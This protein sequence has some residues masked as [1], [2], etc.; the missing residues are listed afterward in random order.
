M[1]IYYVHA[2]KERSINE[3]AKKNSNRHHPSGKNERRSFSGLLL[4]SGYGA[5]SINPAEI[6]VVQRYILHEEEHHTK[7]RFQNRVQSFSKK[8]TKWNM[9]KSTFGINF[10]PSESK[11]SD[12]LYQKHVILHRHFR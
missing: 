3:P 10:F 8:N 7:K 2:V 9:M 5:F 11:F 4:A 6:E 12:S 1:F